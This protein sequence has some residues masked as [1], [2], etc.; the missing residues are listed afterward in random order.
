[1]GRK[2]WLPSRRVRRRSGTAVPGCRTTRALPSVHGPVP[3]R[4]RSETPVQHLPRRVDPARI[5][6]GR[7]T[8]C[9]GTSEI[10]HGE[11]GKTY[12]E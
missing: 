2:E 7:F 8:G 9:G 1:M 11:I 5:R 10:Q 6:P 12:G 3:D 4:R